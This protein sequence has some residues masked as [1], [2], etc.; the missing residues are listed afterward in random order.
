MRGNRLPRT[1]TNSEN[2]YMCRVTA[3]MF[4]LG[5]GL[6]LGLDSINRG[7]CVWHFSCQLSLTINNLE[8][9]HH[10]RLLGQK[11]AAHIQ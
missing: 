11:A 5:F 7:L 8:H 1:V 9:Y 2:L 4:V 6:G 3:V 10:H